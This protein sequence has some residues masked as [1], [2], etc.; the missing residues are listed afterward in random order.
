MAIYNNPPGRKGSSSAAREQAVRKLDNQHNHIRKT[1]GFI[2]N[3][4]GMEGTG[5]RPTEKHFGSC[6]FEVVIQSGETF[7][8]E[9]S[10]S[11]G[12]LRTAHGSNG[13]IKGS[14]CV[15]NYLGHSIKDMSKGKA[16]IVNHGAGLYQDED[17]ACAVFTLSALSGGLQEDASYNFKAGEPSGV[18]GE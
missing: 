17:K 12:E 10:H 9:S 3:V 8:V 2:T 1:Y 4:I 11:Y 7:I 16:T 13:N 5:V 15:I 14:Y 6:W 18:S